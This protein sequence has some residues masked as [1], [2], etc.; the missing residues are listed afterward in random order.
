MRWSC[1]VLLLGSFCAAPGSWAAGDGVLRSV[2]LSPDTQ[3]LAGYRLGRYPEPQ[4][5]GSAYAV[6]AF[7]TEVTAAQIDHPISEHFRIGQFLCKQQAGWPRYVLVQPRLLRVLEAVVDELARRGQPVRTLAVMSGYRT[8]AYNRALGNVAHSRHIYGDAAD[9]FVDEDDDGTM[10]D[11]DGN[12]RLEL[13]D[14]L[15]LRDLIADLLPQTETAAMPAGGLA[16]YG[17]TA[18]HGPFVHVDARGYSARW[19]LGRPA[20]AGTQG[21]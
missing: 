13:A 8:P 6:P 16:A 18:A 7:L 2:P 10:D 17:A 15:W 3:E 20:E 14:A 19:G 9:I 12:G 4:A 1:L 11:L 5:R 21:R